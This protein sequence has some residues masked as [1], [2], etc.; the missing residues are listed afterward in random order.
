MLSKN[1]LIK[2]FHD[3]VKNNTEVKIGTEHEKFIFD[4]N[5]FNLIPYEG[6]VSINS[7]FEEFIKDGWKPLKEDNNIIALTKKRAS[8]TLEPG[9]QFEL[10]GAPLNNIHETC[11]EIN[12]HLL[13]TKKI[14]EKFNIGFLGLGFFPIGELKDVPS[15]PKKRYAEIMTPY[16]K[17][18]KGLGLEMMYQSATVQANFDYISETD[19]QKKI[20]VS[21]F[22]QPIVTGLFSNSPFKNGKLSG[23]ET[24]RAHVWTQTDPDRTGIPK[25]LTE[26]SMSF[27]QYVDYALKVPVYAVIRNSNYYNCTEFTFSE[28]LEGK[29]E[30][31]NPEDI[32]IEDWIN[33]I[34]TIFTEVRLKT[35]IEMRGADAGNYNSLCALP[36][37]WTGILYQ[38]E[39]L[40]ETYNII[41]DFTY[42]DLMN[43]RKDV[44]SKGLDASYG[45]TNGW[46]LAERFLNI[47][48]NG[49]KKRDQKN[50]YGDDETVH[51][52]YLFKVITK[53][54][55]ASRKAIQLY[56][57]DEVLKV[58]ELFESESF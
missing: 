12:N 4:K 1:E 33:H 24:Y 22:I 57:S 50:L 2:Y 3:G 19:M 17:S 52:D 31:F 43:F 51:L 29:N 26:K 7:I 35:F 15:V 36:A 58:K 13:F 5:N 10:S 55:N 40:E 41:S 28:L 39:A 18:L 56:F 16:M 8:I 48:F 34:S 21:A 14:E 11:R 53:K 32:T 54:E 27:E 6:T 49:L 23:F 45:K 44:I 30:N 37:F 9:G 46:A 38:K 20:N 42:E 47:S 25:F